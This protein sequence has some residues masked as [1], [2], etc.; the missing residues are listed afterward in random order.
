MARTKL[1]PFLKE[2]RKRNKSGKDFIIIKIGE[3]GMDGFI[4]DFEWLLRFEFP[5]HTELFGI[6]AYYYGSFDGENDY[7]FYFAW[8]QK[9]F[10][11]LNAELKRRKVKPFHRRIEVKLGKY[12]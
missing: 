3:Y 9:G 1:H 5:K 11:D 6:G 2:C 12:W 4:T 8:S 7:S 10:K